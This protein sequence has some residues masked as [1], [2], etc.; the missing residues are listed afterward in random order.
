MLNTTAK[1][2]ILTFKLFM[3]IPQYSYC[4]ESDGFYKSFTLINSKYPTKY[5]YILHKT[6]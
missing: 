1:M 4:N 2:I 3:I 6:M 5:V